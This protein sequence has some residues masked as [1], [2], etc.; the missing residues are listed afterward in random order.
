MAKAPVMRL[1][2]RRT[3]SS[4]GIAGLAPLR[5]RVRTASAVL[6]SGETHVPEAGRGAPG[7]LGEVF[8]CFRVNFVIGICS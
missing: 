6:A 5:V 8:R 2:A 7:W 3:A 4:R 1:T